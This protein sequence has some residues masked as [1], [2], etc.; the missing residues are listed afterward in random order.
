MIFTFSSYKGGVGRSMALANVAHWLYLRGLKVVLV[1]W[2]LEAPGLEAFFYD[3]EEEVERVRSHL[4]VIDL[5]GAY[6]RQFPHLTGQSGFSD[7]P[8]LDSFLCEL[9]PQVR[10]ASGAAPSGGRLRL[11][12]AG[13]RSGDRFAEYAES[14]QSF[15]WTEFYSRYRGEEYFNWLRGQLLEAGEVVLLDSRTGVSEMSGVCTRQLADVVVVCCAPNVQNLRGALDMVETFVHDDVRRAR[16]RPLEVVILAARVDDADSKGH[17][18]FRAQFE[19]QVESYTPEVFREWKRTLWHLEIPY[20]A[21]YSYRESLVTGVLGANEKLEQAYKHLAAHLALFAPEGSP[22]WIAC[23]AELRVLATVAGKTLKTPSWRAAEAALARFTPEEL[24][25]ARAVLPR[26]VN[27]SRQSPSLD[28]PRRASRE[29]FHLTD[30]GRILVRLT[31]AGVVS[32]VREAPETASPGESYEFADES[33]LKGWPRL[34]G[35]IQERREFLLWRQDLALQ[36]QKWRDS[37]RDPS[38]LLRGEPLEEGRRNAA[39]LPT[40][41]NAAEK[42]FLERSVAAGEAHQREEKE[43]AEREEKA[44]L[45]DE[46]RHR[47]LLRRRRLW[48]YAGTA[49]TILSI[50]A[51]ALWVF[52]DSNLVRRVVTAGAS[53]KATRDDAVLAWR[54]ALLVSGRVDEAL[55]N[56][57][58]MPEALERAGVLAAAAVLLEKTGNTAGAN[59]VAS[60]ALELPVSGLKPEQ[61]AH[62][63][64]QVLATLH[65]GGLPPPREKLK[66]LAEV[67]A[68]VAPLD[69]VAALE[70]LLPIQDPGLR[71]LYFQAAAGVRDPGRQSFAYIALARV[72]RTSA[73]DL[74]LK[75]AE[76]A[77]SAASETADPVLQ[78]DTAITAA[79]VQPTPERR[80]EALAAAR[81]VREPA[82]RVSA[83][84]QI[85]AELGGQEPAWG[86]AMWDEAWGTA[87]EKVSGG[88]RV[89]AVYAVVAAARA[90]GI[91]LAKEPFF[92]ARRSFPESDRAQLLALVV[93]LIVEKGEIDQAIQLSNELADPV[94]RAQVLADVAVKTFQAGRKDQARRA[95]ELMREAMGRVA[96]RDVLTPRLLDMIPILYPAPA[97]QEIARETNTSQAWLKVASAARAAGDADQA[98]AHRE[99]AANLAHGSE[100]RAAVAKS[101]AWTGDLRRARTIAD[102]CEADDRL[103]VYAAII[104][105]HAAH[106]RPE[107]LKLPEVSR[108][109]QY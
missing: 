77:L 18:E 81:A 47:E 28:A 3:D 103:V 96:N 67:L 27:L 99:R 58:R 8:P 46:V 29:E 65:S 105:A 107:L 106:S 45:A 109:N 13:W 12:T 78:A 32:P 23:E 62:S 52:S 41:L 98:P 84:V 20:K 92:V 60:E 33:F 17:D 49:L 51:W 2:D 19:P 31:S 5:L 75:A 86:R 90:S 63:L 10:Y 34:R 91:D 25:E 38:L 104:A 53:L 71:D 42:E 102:E 97:A 70:W 14:V 89:Q 35:W 68:T 95:A 22:L 39:D 85:A 72:S 93:T 55:T 57:R 16:G 6:R 36:E 7:L 66:I 76:A 54:T 1:D 80:N 73:P 87:T 56:L 88:E 64:A 30:A 59:R 94:S 43:R 40:E 11:L 4:G 74:A 79:I 100:E 9:T 61:F 108:L 24:E 15:D 37:G 26:M 69:R 21:Q 44:R 48:N 83:L 82:A 50:A 101:F